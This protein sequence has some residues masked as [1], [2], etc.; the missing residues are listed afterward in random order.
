MTARIATFLYGLI[1]YLIFFVTFLYA[2]GFVGNLVVPKSIDSGPAVPLTEALLIDTLLLSLFAIQHSVMARQWFKRAWT[3]IIA[4]PI[5]RSTYVLLA[6]LVL[7]LLFWQWRP[8]RGVIWD[9]QNPTGRIVLQGLFWMGWGGVLFSTY[10]VDHFSLF[11]LKQVYLYLKGLPDEPTPF[12]TPVLYKVVRHPL[13]LGF[14]VAFWSTP[15][16]TLGHL[17]F[18]AVCTAYIVLAIQFEERDLMEF[19]GDSYRKYRTQVSM[20]LPVRFGRK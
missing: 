7:S 11:G 5:E 2:I 14:I 18:A 9:V 3:K 20:L 10:L 13:Y 19:Y 17:F 6:S 16:M 8:M 4:Q 15:R 1:C 12:K